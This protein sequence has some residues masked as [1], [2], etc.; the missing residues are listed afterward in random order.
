M[1]PAHSIPHQPIPT[2]R[3][4][5]ARTHIATLTL[6]VLLT[7]TPCAIAQEPDARA[8][9]A[10]ALELRAAGVAGVASVADVLAAMPGAGR[11]EREVLPLLWGASFANA[12]VTLGRLSS[13]NPVAL[14]Y[15]PLLDIALL[16][17][18]QREGDGYQV[19]SLR[20][21]PGERLV[22]TDAEVAPQPAWLSA[23]GGAVAALSLTTE[24]RL[25]AFRLAHP[26]DASEPAE[27]QA[28]FASAAAD[29]RAVLPRLVWNAAQRDRWID[30]APLWLE[31][32]LT[33]VENAL[34]SRDSAALVAAAPDTDAATANALAELPDGFA[35][36]LA[37]DM[38]IESGGQDRLLIGSLL[39]DG[40]VY[41]LALCRLDSLAEE[42]NDCALRRL[43]F[44]SLLES[45]V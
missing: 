25:D 32:T 33:R 23:E 17:F 36:G 9:A 18:W 35:A 39:T 15:D 38:I 40:D 44:V 26:P 6:A 28:T 41:V 3:A 27:D 8:F 43:V 30:Q 21:L 37:L 20:A 2:T 12:I 31:P 1:I 10:H 34:A 14:Y 24:A 22:D 29:V 19:T 5:V 42:S 45:S 7:F 16:T 4:A 13:P 11:V